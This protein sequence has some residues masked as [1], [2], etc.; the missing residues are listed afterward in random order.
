MYLWRPWEYAPRVSYSWLT[1][2]LL[3][4]TLKPLTA[5]R[6]RSWCL[7][8]IQ[9]WLSSPHQG[10]E[11]WPGQGRPGTSLRGDFGSEIPQQPGWISL[12][13]ALQ[14][15]M[16]PPTQTSFS[17]PFTWATPTLPAL[18][19]PLRISCLRHTLYV[20][21]VL[22]TAS[23]RSWTNT[24]LTSQPFPKY[25]TNYSQINKV[26]TCFILRI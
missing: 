25:T 12:S 5:L 23:Q 24:L 16:L 26:S 11:C 21:H 3:W 14:P 13:N 9:P 7:W 2:G 8:A 6:W 1:E 19:Y 20:N 22:A 17:P 18:S 4:V 10:H 15:K